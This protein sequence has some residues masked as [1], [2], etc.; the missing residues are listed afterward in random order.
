MGEKEEGVSKISIQGNR[1]EHTCPGTV[2]A[3]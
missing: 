3:Q 1:F 2:I